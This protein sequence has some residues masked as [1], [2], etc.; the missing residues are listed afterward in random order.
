M[1]CA[2]A[3]NSW[4]GSAWLPFKAAGSVN[5]ILGG[6]GL[7]KIEPVV[8][9]STVTLNTYYDSTT[10]PAQFLAGPTAS[11]GAVSFRAIS[12]TDLP[13]AGVSQGAVAVSGDGLR[14]DGVNIEIDNDITPAT[15][16]SLCTVNAKGL[17]TAASTVQPT[18]L[19]L[20][21][22]STV[23]AVM[24]GVDMGV[25]ATGILSLHDV[26]ASPGT[27]TKV[28]CNARG[29]VTVGTV[30]AP[31]DIPGLAADQITSGE[32]DPH[33]YADHSIGMEKL[34][35]YA[36]SYIQEVQPSVVDPILAIGTY[37]YQPSTGQLRIF[38]GNYYAPVGF[39][40]LSQENLRWGGTV[41]ATTGLVTG[42]TDLGAQGGLAI[43]LP[44][45]VA[46]DA[47]GGMYLL[48]D[49]DG[50]NISVTP[51]TVYT[52][53]DWCLCIN[54]AE[55]W[56]KIDAQGGGGGGGASLLGELLD[57]TLTNETNEQALV[58]NFA[59]QQWVNAAVV[60]TWNGRTGA[61]VP[62]D[63]D[64]TM[65]LL[66]GVVITTAQVG[67]VLVFDGSDWVNQAEIDGGSF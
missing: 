18:D 29:L 59:M 48:V 65:D 37:W 28:T 30:L 4:N 61:V 31:T 2:G 66:G 32:F 54:E 34:A 9:G 36:V 51:G 5:S 7:V 39:G 23:G 42:T 58:F 49:T 47:L 63:G 41:D 6:T 8:T 62:E 46:T 14:M 21:T 40:R 16:P 64:Y 33:R 67:D 1:Q 26:L 27:Y 56:I 50:N 22:D 57:V 12:S 25:D 11:G 13:T 20:A 55:G 53:G 19:P 43:G 45:P 52:V 35:N 3:G 38:D 15:V 60:N 44:I 10:Q 17:V 24:P